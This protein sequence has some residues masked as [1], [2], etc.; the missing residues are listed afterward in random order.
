MSE[1]L[2][3]TRH[4]LERFAAGEPDWDLYAEDFQLVNLHDAPWQPSPGPQGIQEWL[5]FTDEIA[6]EWGIEF[7]GFEELDSNRVLAHTRLWA[8]FQ[9]TGIREEMKVV[10]LSTFGADGRIVR[11]ETFYT[12]EEALKAAGLP[13]A[14][15]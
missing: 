10:A 12:R 6:E 3:R 15:D 1:N 5:D 2:E 11:G 9:T 14:D 13:T 8:K 7:D 4:G